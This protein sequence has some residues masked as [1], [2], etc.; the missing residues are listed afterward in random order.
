MTLLCCNSTAC[1]EQYAGVLP[2]CVCPMGLCNI[3]G[4]TS[5][6]LPIFPCDDCFCG[7]CCS[8]ASNL[9]A[10]PCGYGYFLHLFGARVQA[11]VNRI[12]QPTQ[13]E[14][15]RKRSEFTT[16]DRNF[17][18]Y[19]SAINTSFAENEKAGL[20]S[21]LSSEGAIQTRA[22]VAVSAIEETAAGKL[23]VCMIY[24]VDETPS[25]SWADR[26][27][28]ILGY[29]KEPKKL[30]AMTKNMFRDATSKIR[31]PVPTMSTAPVPLFQAMNGKNSDD[32]V[33]RVEPSSQGARKIAN[34]ILA[35]SG[36]LPSSL[37]N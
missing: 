22:E 35:R 15:E 33:Q 9:C 16:S 29:D 4:S 3:P 31:S 28:G 12:I 23:M 34:L 6:A 37:S 20:D 27:L 25:G 21:S 8:C 36:L 32:Y 1:I 30:Q 18:N 14:R 2:C 13:W 10:F 5:I 26:A 11:F 17:R 24:F 7:C 19:G